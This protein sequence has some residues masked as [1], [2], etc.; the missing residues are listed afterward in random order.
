MRKLFIQFYLLLMASFL[1]VTLLVGGIYKLTAER[2]S[3]K[4]LTDLMD[5]VMTLLERELAEV[6]Q[7]NWPQQLASLDLDL[8]FPV[9]IEYTQD[10]PLDDES[11]AALNRGEIV[12]VEDRS[13]C[14]EQI[15]DTNYVLVAGPI[16]Y[17]SFQHEIA[18][19]DYLL[20]GL[21]GISLGLPVFI[22]MRPHWRDLL[23]LERTARRLGRGDLSARINLPETSSLQRLGR[24]FDQMADNIQEVIASKKRLT[25]NVA[26]ELRTPLV[27]LRYR[28]EMLDPPLADD[29]QQGIVRDISHLETLIDEMLT[30]AR[31]DRPQVTLTYQTFSPAEWL[32]Q[33]QHDWQS[34]L[35]GKQLH[36]ETIP[37]EWHWQG[38]IKLLDRMLDN[39]VG[40]A[41]RYS[42]QQIR[43]AL[44][45]EP[46]W[47]IIK[48]E[49]DGPGIPAEQRATIFDA[50]VRLDPSRD[51]A[52]GG[53]G[54]GLAI[55]QGIMLAH[56]G[57]AVAEESTLGGACFICRWPEAVQ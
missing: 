47:H 10:Q 42:Q 25:D 38:D 15:P 33:R 6:P 28:L 23:L 56:K 41:L 22:W 4:S 52:T 11:F 43:I 29:A 17:L 19:F 20:L 49:D 44:S 32:Q 26:H 34:L 31:L 54:L 21:L 7:E 57:S 37:Y 45:Q 39:L 18:D 3:E 24:A 40:N 55:V 14:M 50:F 48:V 13:L 35:D 36:V 30:Y 27:R 12:I 8:S 46:G 51:R 2:S 5:S 9:H 53:F 16:P 1:L